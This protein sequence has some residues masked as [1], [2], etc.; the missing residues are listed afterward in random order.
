MIVEQ[1]ESFADAVRSSGER[2]DL[3]T[4]EFPNGGNPKNRPEVHPALYEL[5]SRARQGLSVCKVF[6]VCDLEKITAV[7]LRKTPNIGKKTLKEIQS[8]MNKY[9][10]HFR[11][12]VTK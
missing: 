6:M 3:L 11:D 1:L 9:G 10:L 4:A 5:S 12:G 8:W 7:Q 2:I